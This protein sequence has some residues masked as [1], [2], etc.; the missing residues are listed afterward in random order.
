MLIDLWNDRGPS[1]QRKHDLAR[2]RYPAETPDPV[3]HFAALRLPDAGAKDHALQ[4]GARLLDAHPANRW[5]LLAQGYLFQERG[6]TAEAAT[7]FESILDLP[8]Q[9]PDFLRRLFRAWSWMALAQ[10][11][12]ERDPA[13]ARAH[14]RE[15]IAS[16]VT[17]QLLNDARRMLDE[18]GPRHPQRPR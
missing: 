5:M 2:T 15:I 6:R 1:A 9:E 12:A 10:M 4:D 13:K 17:G 14:L 3:V 8:N 11:S 18:L 7:C 16:G